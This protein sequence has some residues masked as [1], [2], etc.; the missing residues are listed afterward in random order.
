[1]FKSLIAI[2]EG[3]KAALQAIR[4]NAMRS[5]LTCLG[6]IIGVA[7]VITVVAVM[8]GFTKQINNMMADM[9]PDVTTIK[10]FTSPEQEMVGVRSKLTYEDFLEL[11]GK[12]KEA[13]TMTALMFTWR[14]AGGAQY[15]N[16]THNSRVMG[17]EQDY[18]KAYRTY[19]DKGRFIR[20]E[21]D[22]KRRRVAFIGPSLIEKLNLPKNPVGEYI[23]LGGEWFRIIG[24]AESQGSL[25]G[26]DQD[27]Y[28]NIPISTMSA[29]EGA[30]GSSNVQIMFRLK[31]EA[32]E[33]Q[34]TAQITRILRQRHKI[35]DGQDSDFE[36]E[37]A[38]KARANFDKFTGS[39]T[40]I[41][42]GIV[43]ISL[44]VGGIGVMNIMLVSVTER[45]RVIGTLKALGATPGFI[46]LQFLVEAVVLSL[47]GGLIGLAL[48]YGMAAMISAMV[49]SMPDAFIPGW[50]IML[51]FGFTSMIGIVFGLAPAI[52]AARLNPIDALRYE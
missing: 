18:Q 37:T 42:A 43:G 15:G 7:A 24:V 32:N 6:I 50:A 5:A 4:A 48:G 9:A 33:E 51:S 25:L 21:D 41:T 16:K 8:Q 45:T 23:K 19:P 52:K 35:K 47:F 12:I 31:P 1:M 11:K 2:M 44:I 26:F 14:F 27:D 38:E 3:T 28:I 10:P 49:P 34:I 30:M 20:A 17:T 29:L 22:E 46:M 40:A 39:A 13:E 36:F